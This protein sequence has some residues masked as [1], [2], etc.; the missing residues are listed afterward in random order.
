MVKKYD[1]IVFE[2][3]Y[4]KIKIL[5]GGEQNM[6]FPLTKFITKLQDKFD[7]HKPQAEGVVFVDAKYTSK[8]MSFLRK[9]QP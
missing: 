2:K 4:S 5:I 9:H 7:R 3:N 1:T 6:V 8:K